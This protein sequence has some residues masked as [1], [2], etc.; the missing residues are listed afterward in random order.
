MGAFNWIKTQDLCPSCM[1]KSELLFQTHMA[2]SFDG[3]ESGRFCQNEYLVGEKMRWWSPDSESFA[4]W[5]DKYKSVKVSS[6]EFQEC[7]YGECLTCKSEIFGIISFRN[8]IPIKLDLVGLE[9]DWPER[10]P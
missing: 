10:F 1:K 6:E 8:L 3:D 5:I 7:C 9:K 2:S 4:K